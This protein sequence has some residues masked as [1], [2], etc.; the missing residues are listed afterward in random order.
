MSAFDEAVGARIR[1]AREAAGA[2]QAKLAGVLGVTA[3]ALSYWEAGVRSPSIG[4]VVE[5]AAA[6]AVPVSWL[7][8]GADDAPEMY[9][10]GRRDGW[11]ACAKQIMACARRASEMEATR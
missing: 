7:L 1:E 10:A 6:L 5:I 3:T 4:T 2:T 11:E 8:L 9:A